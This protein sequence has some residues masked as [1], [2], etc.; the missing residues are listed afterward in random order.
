M[1]NEQ[2][3]QGPAGGAPNPDAIFDRY[4]G[5]KESFDVNAAAI[6]ERMLRPGESAEQ[7]REQWRA[8]LQKRGVT[9]GLM[10]R[11][12]FRAFVA[13]RMGQP[14]AG[15][16]PNPDAIFDR[17]AGGKESFD[18]NTAAIPERM[19]RPGESAEQRRGQWRAF[20]QKRGVTN[21]LMTRELFR[22]FV[23]QHRPAN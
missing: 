2:Q 4:A 1:A 11:E 8:F 14:Q 22:A 16:A 20:L 17:Y 13:G 3:S 18:V 12:L 10:T 6:P 21:G 7:R 23:A 19:L 5:G 15:G 9:N